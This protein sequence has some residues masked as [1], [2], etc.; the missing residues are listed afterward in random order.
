VGEISNE[1]SDFGERNTISPFLSF[2]PYNYNGLESSAV[3]GVIGP[4]WIGF[5]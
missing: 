5:E 4:V 2:S 3:R 1:I